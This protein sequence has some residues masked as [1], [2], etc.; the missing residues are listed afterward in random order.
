[1]TSAH[2][3]SKQ[4]F[5]EPRGHLLEERVFMEDIV[6]GPLEGLL[7]KFEAFLVDLRVDLLL[8]EHS[9]DFSQVKLHLKRL[10]LHKL[11]DGLTF[12]HAANSGL[13]EGEHC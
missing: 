8:R 12:F 2:T 10:G 3:D 1:L 7:H 9:V 6:D 5:F 4:L 13:D 11:V